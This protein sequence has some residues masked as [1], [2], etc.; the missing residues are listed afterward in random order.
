[1][2]DVASQRRDPDA[3]LR[4]LRRARA[5]RRVGLSL[6]VLG[7]VLAALG[8]FGVRYRTVV[9]RGNGVTL[10]VRYP[11]LGRPGLAISWTVAVVRAGGFSDDV[12]LAVDARYFDLFDENGMEPEPSATRSAGDLVIWTF[13]RPVGDRL[14]IDLD[15]RLSPTWALKAD[16]SVAVLESEVA[17]AR[18]AFTTWNL[19]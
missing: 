5:L 2:A 15:A 19:P 9:A 8:L 4:R 3:T 13:D 10:E 1:V 17:V 11:G 16:G 6:L 14:V 12:E 7:A 18:V